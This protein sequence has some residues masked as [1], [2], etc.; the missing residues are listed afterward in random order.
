M[1]NSLTISVHMYI[2]NIKSTINYNFIFRPQHRLPKNFRPHWIC[3]DKS[4]PSSFASTQVPAI[5][6]ILNNY[7]SEN[8]F[9]LNAK[10]LKKLASLHKKKIMQL[11]RVRANKPII[12][13]AAFINSVFWPSSW[14]G[15]R[16]IPTG[17]WCFRRGANY[18]GIRVLKPDRS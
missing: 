10:E 15:V 5:I 3:S 18:F 8:A 9:S 6:Y 1:G 14:G 4:D 2:Q 17:D 16:K 7:Y 13:K 12:S 11:Q